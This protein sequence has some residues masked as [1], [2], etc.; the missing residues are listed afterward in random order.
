MEPTKVLIDNRMVLL[1]ING[2]STV[3][4]QGALD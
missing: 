3:N 1:T 2:I 4:L